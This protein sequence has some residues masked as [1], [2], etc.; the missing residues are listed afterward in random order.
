MTRIERETEVVGKM[1]ALYCRGKEHNR[2]LC[3]RCRELNE[4]AANRLR[5]CRF[6]ERKPSCKQ[7]PIHCYRPDMRE[8][9]REVMRY[10]G[11]RMLFRE[12]LEALRHLWREFRHGKGDIGK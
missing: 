9:M 5:N 3:P 2:E 6:A 12:P 8:R 7:C 10:A 11:P 1:I 4:Y